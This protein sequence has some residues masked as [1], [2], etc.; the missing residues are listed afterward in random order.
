MAHSPKRK[1]PL[2]DKINNYLNQKNKNFQLENYYIQNNHDMTL[3]N[4]LDE[5]T[6]GIT[7]EAAMKHKLGDHITLQ[8]EAIQIGRDLLDS[9]QII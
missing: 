2:H 7:V 4:T 9:L 5:F 3:A 8:N 1:H 6:L